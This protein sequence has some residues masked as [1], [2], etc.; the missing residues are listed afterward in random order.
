MIDEL[1]IKAVKIR[2]IIFGSSIAWTKI[3]ISSTNDI[4]IN[5]SDIMVYRT[6]L[7]DVEK[8]PVHDP[9][10][11]IY[12]K[13]FIY[14][15]DDGS[16]KYNPE[17]I[18]LNNLFL[19]REMDILYHKIINSDNLPL[20]AMDEDLKSNPSFQEMEKIKS[21]DGLQKFYIMNYNTNC[22]YYIPYFVSLFKIK[23][24]DSYSGKVYDVDDRHLWIKITVKKPKLEPI[25]MHMQ[26]LKLGD[27]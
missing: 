25:D 5:D 9:I 14:I 2:T 10:C 23:K 1:I 3:Y 27:M 4:I 11:F 8:Y 16:I 6:K 20:L 24:S 13:D 15:Q 18:E 12:K 22:R 7:Q 26:I 17:H 19:M 21:G